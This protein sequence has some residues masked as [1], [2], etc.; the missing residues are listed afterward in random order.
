M[1]TP[2]KQNV[3]E[4]DFTPSDTTRITLR[5]KSRKKPELNSE[6]NF[7]SCSEKENTPTKTVARL[8]PIKDTKNIYEVN[9]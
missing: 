2:E 6:C 9:N 5:K 7:G 4:K 1:N 8:T 3:R